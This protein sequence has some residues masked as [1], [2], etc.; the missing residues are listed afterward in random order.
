[1]LKI[2]VRIGAWILG[3]SFSDKDMRA[4][5]YLPIW[6]LSFGVI[7]IVAGIVVGIYAVFHFSV[8]A[9]IGVVCCL[10][11]GVAA[12]MC[13]KNQTIKILSNDSFEYSTFLGNKKIYYFNQITSLR[14]NND[15]MT[16]FVGG[17]KVH[18]ESCAILSERFVQR[19]DE[20]LEQV[21]SD[22]DSQQ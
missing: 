9:V 22:T 8:A 10:G 7:L 11:L 14:M 21:Y 3:E 19:V 16:L 5:M 6:I 4:D 18:I 13:W 2:L 17:D 1:M 15:S 20:V 12:L